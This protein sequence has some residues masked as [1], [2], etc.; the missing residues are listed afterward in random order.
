MGANQG[1]IDFP[2]MLGLYFV[3]SEIIEFTAFV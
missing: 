2:L 3:I 1:D